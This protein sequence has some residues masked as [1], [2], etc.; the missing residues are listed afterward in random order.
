MTKDWPKEY[1][2][3]LTVERGYSEKTKEAYKED[4]DNFFVFLKDSGDANYLQIDHRDV[5]VYLSELNEQSYSRNT[6]SRKIAS[7]RSFYH[8]LL[9]HEVIEENP[10]SYVHLKKRM[11]NYLAFFMKKRLQC[12]L[13][14]FKETNLC[15]KEI[16]LY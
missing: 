5:R 3:Y 10:F 9:K 6:V 13:I 1:Y 4:I 14:V 11:S 16:A 7:L 12:Y 8:F 2:R 15:N